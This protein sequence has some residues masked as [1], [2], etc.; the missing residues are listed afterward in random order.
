VDA[1]ADQSFMRMFR[2]ISLI[3]GNSATGGDASLVYRPALNRER[4]VG[5]V[6]A[7]PRAL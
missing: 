7:A 6:V 5:C 2:L 3:S 4:E 1:H